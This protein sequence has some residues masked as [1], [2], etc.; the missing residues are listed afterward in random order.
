MNIS[1]K[2][3]LNTGVRLKNLPNQKREFGSKPG[4]VHQLFNTVDTHTT[5][6]SV[7]KYDPTVPL[8]VTQYL[9]T[10][11]PQASRNE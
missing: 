7:A 2:S 11:G 4:I 8:K 3:V 10:L 6:Y 9:N 1:A 5:S